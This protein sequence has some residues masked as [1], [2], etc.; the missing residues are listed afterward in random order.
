MPRWLTRCETDGLPSELWGVGHV[1]S[2]LDRD[3]PFLKGERNRVKTKSGHDR[4]R[5]RVLAGRLLPVGQPSISR[6]C[7]AM[8]SH[9]EAAMLL[10]H[11]PSPLVALGGQTARDEP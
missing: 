11:M 9:V 5:L 1:D 3:G 2:L 4:D 6:F 10:E 7:S 8:N